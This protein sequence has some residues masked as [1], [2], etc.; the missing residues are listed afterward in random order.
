MINIYLLLLF[1]CTFFSAISQI[2][3]KRSADMEHKNWI[4]E[5]LN[6]RVITAYS[7]YAVVLLL[8]IWAF[9]KV[10]MKYGAVIDTFTYVFVMVLSILLLRENIPKGRIVGNLIIMAGVI[11]YTLAP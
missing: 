1:G 10:D 11:I 2:L 8:N 7:I 5:Y 3:L 9:T 6:W 4:R